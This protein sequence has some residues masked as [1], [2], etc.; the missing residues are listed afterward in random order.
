[1]RLQA[2]AA[3]FRVN[4]DYEVSL[5]EK[6]AGITLHPNQVEAVRAAIENGVQIVT[7]GPA[8]ERLP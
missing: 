6:E 2:E 8:P 1:M 3:D 7:G 4:T 5:F